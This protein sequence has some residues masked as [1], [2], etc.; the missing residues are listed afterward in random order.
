MVGVL[1]LLANMGGIGGGGLLVPVGLTF[2]GFDVKNAIYLSNL[3]ICV[4]SLIR[5]LLNFKKPHPLKKGRG[6]LVDMS[7]SALMLPMIVSGVSCGTLVSIVTPSIVVRISFVVF[8][9][10]FMAGLV[11]KTFKL[12]I[13]ESKNHDNEENSRKLGGYFS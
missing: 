3:S 2:F 6:I 11:I 13:S 12:Y 10:Y 7:L 8:L 1:L 5:Y 9:A 4:S